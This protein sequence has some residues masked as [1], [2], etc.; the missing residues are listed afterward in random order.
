MDS[1]IF[2][3][4]RVQNRIVRAMDL[5]PISTLIKN[6]KNASGATANIIDG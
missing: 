6:G 4:L 1:L 2:E 3:K 5:L